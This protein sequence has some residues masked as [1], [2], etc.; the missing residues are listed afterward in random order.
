[1]TTILLVDDEKLLVKGLKRSLEQAGYT[2]FTAYNG[3]ECLNKLEE[4]KVDLVVLDL[5]LPEI[6]GLD[7]CRYI[8]KS[9]Q[10][11]IIMLTALGED[12]DKIV[13]LEV[14]ADDYITKPFNTREL[15]ARIKAVL[16]RYSFS[17]EN[18]KEVQNIE[19]S[20]LIIDRERCKVLR[21]KE[22]LELTAREF[23]LLEL[24]AS[25]P[26][27]VYT[28]EKLMELV[29]G[30]IYYA[31]LRSVDVHI[32]RLREKLEENPKKPEFII[33]KWGVGYFFRGED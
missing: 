16:R 11:P 18:T 8:R 28:R 15:L 30:S 33:T 31:D 19:F 26:E 21:G 5:M 23:D 14:G 17:V 7:V 22:E 12:V 25:H 4:Q 1:M 2:V 27:R 13:G 24:M 20:N 9:S 6:D 10:L 3:R 32:R 29:W